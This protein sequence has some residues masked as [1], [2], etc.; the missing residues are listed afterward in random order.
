MKI[1]DSFY[2]DIKRINIAHEF[3]L[4]ENNKCEYPDGRKYYGMV[5]CIDGEAEYLFRSRNR[6]TVQKG[7]VLF[8]SSRAAY[9]I[10]VKNEYRHYTVNFELHDDF[11]DFGFLDKDFYL[12]KTEN[13]AW[14]AHLFK[15]LV[16]RWQTKQFCFEA[17]SVASL[18]ELMALFV[19][20]IYDK[21]YNLSARR[22][23]QP[24]KEYIECNFNRYINL[25]MLANL[26]DMSVTNFRREWAKHYGESALRYRDKVRLNYAKEYLGVGYYSVGDVAEKCG[27]AD[28]NYFVRFFKKHIGIS[29]GKYKEMPIV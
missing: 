5:Y 6:Q 19:S 14:Y 21:E 2:I 15:E 18:Y 3:L 4:N 9:S 27:F 28:V 23:L 22:R 17:R 16:A 24:A 10:A 1:N 20:E 25:D 7:D 26:C 12:L 29:P 13:A 8:L 11:S